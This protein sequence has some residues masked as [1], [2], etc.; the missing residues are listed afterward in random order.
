MAHHMIFPYSEKN[1]ETEVIISKKHNYRRNRL[2]KA[3][4]LDK[5]AHRTRAS[6]EQHLYK[7]GYID[8][9]GP[10]L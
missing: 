1:I 4:S 6:Q 8:E 5:Q 9:N 3:K 7:S 10:T 2:D